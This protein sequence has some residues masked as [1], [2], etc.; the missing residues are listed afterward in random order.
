MRD[1]RSRCVWSKHV[2]FF[3]HAGHVNITDD[4]VCMMDLRWSSNPSFFLFCFLTRTLKD[5]LMEPNTFYWK[6]LKNTGFIFWTVLR[7]IKFET[8]KKKSRPHVYRFFTLLF[9]R[10]TML[11]MFEIFYFFSSLPSKKK[12]SYATALS[13]QANYNRTCGLSSFTLHLFFG[14]VYFH[15]CSA[16]VFQHVCQWPL[17]GFI[18]PD[19]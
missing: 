10:R 4:S 2:S 17:T 1:P 14:H 16:F 11:E 7:K 19:R 18:L 3:Q 15:L 5:C 6:K 13:K 8:N 9:S 12:T